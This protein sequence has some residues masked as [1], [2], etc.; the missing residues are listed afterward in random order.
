MPDRRLDTDLERDAD[1]RD[2]VDTEVAR[3]LIQRCRRERGQGV[4]VE[5]TVDPIGGKWGAAV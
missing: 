4:L 1:D 5:V 2:S 3:C